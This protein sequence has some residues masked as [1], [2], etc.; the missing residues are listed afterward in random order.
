MCS[1][2][3]AIDDFDDLKSHAKNKNGDLWI[4]DGN[5]ELIIKDFSKG[6]LV[7]TDFLF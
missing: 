1:G 2:W 6:D 3:K 5:H 7:E 4:V